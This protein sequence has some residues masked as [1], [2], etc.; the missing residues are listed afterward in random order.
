[1]L[2]KKYTQQ[3]ILKISKILLLKPK[4]LFEPKSFSFLIKKNYI[5][6]IYIYLNYILILSLLNVLAS[7]PNG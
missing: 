4:I 3:C 7:W 6:N 5:M 2:E 1:M